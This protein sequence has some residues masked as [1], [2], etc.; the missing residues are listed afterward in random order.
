M[1]AYR[2]HLQA[3]RHWFAYRAAATGRRRDARIL[4]A[5]ALR[6]HP[7]PS[8]W[9]FSGVALSIARGRLQR[10]FGRSPPLPLYT[11]AIW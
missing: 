7:L 4:L 10:R 11:E 3:F 5:E 1:S 2:T 6:Y 9:H 8:A